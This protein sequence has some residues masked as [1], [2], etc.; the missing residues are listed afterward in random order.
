MNTHV[1]PE[2]NLIN[3]IAAVGIAF[4]YIVLFSLVKEPDRQKLSAIVAAGAGAA[5]WSGG[6]G[7]WEFAFG[8][9][10]LFVAFK[11][12]ANYYFIGIA[13]LLHTS[14][15]VVHHLY[16]NP[17]VSFVPSSSAGCAVCDPILAIW[18]FFRAPSVFR[19]F[20]KPSIK[21]S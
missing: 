4:I 13:W 20:R 12:L 14:W 6:M 16:A 3:V 19:L 2:F 11:G 1:A 10:M 18:Y 15:D 5:Y 21:I 8:T 17:I 9:I 7:V